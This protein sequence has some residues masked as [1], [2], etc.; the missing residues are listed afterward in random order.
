MIVPAA[1]LV[2][3]RQ[4]KV[5]SLVRE[6]FSKAANL[7]MSLSLRLLAEMLGMSKPSLAGTLNLASALDCAKLLKIQRFCQ[8]HLDTNLAHLQRDIYLVRPPVPDPR[9]LGTHS[10]IFFKPAAKSFFTASLNAWRAASSFER[11]GI[12]NTMLT[13]AQSEANIEHLGSENW[14]LKIVKTAMQNRLKEAN[15]AARLGA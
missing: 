6:L 14:T 10:R 3:A 7:G 12:L 5:Q 8:E 11:V 13:Q 1:E 15:R 4:S 2:L 9:S